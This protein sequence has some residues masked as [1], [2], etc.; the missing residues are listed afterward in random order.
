[1]CLNEACSFRHTKLRRLFC[2]IYVKNLLRIETFANLLKHELG[3]VKT[4]TINGQ[5]INYVVVSRH[6]TAWS[7]GFG[8]FFLSDEEADIWRDCLTPFDVDD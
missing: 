2:R 7:L 6:E 4:T 3:N 1:M 5:E 8:H